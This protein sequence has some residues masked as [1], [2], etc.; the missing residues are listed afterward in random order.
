MKSF[1]YYKATTVSQAI[2]LLARHGDRA[3]LLAG[4]SD[5][6]ALMKDR[7]EGPKYHA[8]QHLLD[9]SG[10]KELAYV[11]EQKNSV[12]IGAGTTISDIAAS[13]LVAQRYPLLAQAAAQVAVPQIRNVGTLGGNLCQR[14]RCWYFRGKAFKDCFRKGGDSCYAATGENQYHAIFGA[15][16]CYMVCPSDLAPA[17]AALYARVEIA[18][19]K[20]SKIIPM[21]QFYIKP[22]RNLLK[23]TTLGPA[24]MVVAVEIPVSSPASRGIYLK[25]KERQAFDFALVS[26]AV[27]AALRGDT[28]TDARIL[29]GG[30]APFPIRAMDAEM[31]LKGKR[32]TQSVAAAC[33]AA[34][35]GAS[36]LSGNAYKVTATK[37]LLEQALTSLA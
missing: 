14:P 1:D 15:E 26:V 25:L 19:V 33:E 37:G 29:F 30:I 6:L 12:K 2:S 24:E 22:G 8:P 31:V 17:L 3:A 36:P 10:I 27:T 32:I 13:P 9:I 34:V 28:V 35:K 23:E 18:T 5:I 7:V 4:G 11:K 20:G 16:N 21:D